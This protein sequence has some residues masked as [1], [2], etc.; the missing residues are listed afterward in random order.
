MCV[1]ARARDWCAPPKWISLR[2]GKHGRKRQGERKREAEG[3]CHAR[4]IGPHSLPSFVV[5]AGGAEAGARFCGLMAV[6]IIPG[7]FAG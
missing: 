1:C 5:V 7:N 3:R 6:L 2:A 4:R